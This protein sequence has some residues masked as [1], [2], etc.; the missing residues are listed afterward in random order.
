MHQREST[1]PFAR[2]NPAMTPSWRAVWA[3]LARANAYGGTNVKIESEEENTGA[4]LLG[5]FLGVLDGVR[6]VDI[7]AKHWPPGLAKHRPE[8]IML[9]LVNNDDETVELATNTVMFMTQGGHVRVL[10]SMECNEKPE[11]IARQMA[12]AIP[13]ERGVSNE[14]YEEAL[15]IEITRALAPSQDDADRELLEAFAGRMLRKIGIQRYRT[16]TIEGWNGGQVRVRT[17]ASPDT[18][19][20]RTRRN[21]HDQ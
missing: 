16:Y 10:V 4:P 6:V 3:T 18:G 8:T 15:L 7:G 13:I 17:G 1:M 2:L 14:R 11:F 5:P 20:P 12:W 9:R 21:E 19:Q